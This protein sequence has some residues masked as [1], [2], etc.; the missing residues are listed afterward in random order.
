MDSYSL[1]NIC[2][3]AR[4]PDSTGF[5]HEI[6]DGKGQQVGA[7]FVTNGHTFQDDDARRQYIVGKLNALVESEGAEK[8]AEAV[9]VVLQL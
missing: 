6:S 3:G 7:V 5:Q 9:A 8:T 2:G 1:D 4:Q